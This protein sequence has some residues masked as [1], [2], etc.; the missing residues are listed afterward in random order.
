MKAKCRARHVVGDGVHALENNVVV[1]LYLLPAP[2]QGGKFVRRTLV[3]QRHAVFEFDELRLLLHVGLDSLIRAEPD[4][5]EGEDCGDQHGPLRKRPVGVA[6][7]ERRRR[8]GERGL[9]AV[10][11][12]QKRPPEQHALFV[13]EIAAARREADV[14]E[15][16]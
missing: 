13:V 8:G 12:E 16:I 14:P 11:D 4:H 10:G 7:N 6:E 3:V 15:F 9:H 2:F 1:G 5:D